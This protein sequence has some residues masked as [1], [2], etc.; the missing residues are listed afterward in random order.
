[1][2]DEIQMLRDP[3]RGY[4]W[5]RALLGVVADEIHLCGEEAALELL[6]RL[7]RNTNDTIEV[8]IFNGIFGGP[9]QKVPV[10]FNK[11]EICWLNSK[12]NFL[13]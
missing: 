7:L 12:R 1:M 10:R 4:A 6:F 8:I 3:E 13:V 9:Q 2:I 11:A 5:T